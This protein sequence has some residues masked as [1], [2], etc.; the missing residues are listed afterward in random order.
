MKTVTQPNTTVQLIIPEQCLK[1]HL[2]D[3]SFPPFLS[4]DD[5]RDILKGEMFE[6]PIRVIQAIHVYPNIIERRPYCNVY[7]PNKN[8]QEV[9]VYDGTGWK[10]RTVNEWAVTLCRW[11]YRAWT[12]FDDSF[13]DRDLLLQYVARRADDR[14]WKYMLQTRR[15]CVLPSGFRKSMKKLFGFR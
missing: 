8:V 12:Q 1:A 6:I 4:D 14:M 11:V 2:S 5:V 10:I 7:W 3:N 15:G 9:I 13:G